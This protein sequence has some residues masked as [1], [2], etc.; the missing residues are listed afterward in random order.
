MQGRGEVKMVLKDFFFFQKWR[1]KLGAVTNG[2][3]FDLIISIW[4]LSQGML[5]G[6]V[7]SQNPCWEQFH[8]IAQSS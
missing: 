5:C 1:N 7:S 8:E 2:L 4:S 6:K 3:G